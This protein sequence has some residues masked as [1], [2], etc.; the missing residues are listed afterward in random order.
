MPLTRFGDIEV[1][2]AKRTVR[3]GNRLLTLKPKELELLLYFVSH[4]DV[5]LSRQELL[6]QVWGYSFAGASRTVDVHVRWL[7][8]KL[9]TDP[10]RPLYLRTA[11]GQGY[12]LMSHE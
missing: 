9:E 6:E 4:R 12:V 2:S 1:D 3:R 7:R 8:A 11:R 5:V 10:D